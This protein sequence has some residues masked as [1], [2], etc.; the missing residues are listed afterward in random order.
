VCHVN[1]D[2][3]S[4]YRPT[5]LSA[6][7]LPRGCHATLLTQNPPCAALPIT[8]KT[9]LG[10][11]TRLLRYVLLAFGFEDPNGT[12]SLPARY[13][14][15]MHFVVWRGQTLETWPPS[16]DISS[17]TRHP[18]WILQWQISD[19]QAQSPIL[20]SHLT[21]SRTT[22]PEKTTDGPGTKPSNS[23]G[24]PGPAPS[25]LL[26]GDLSPTVSTHLSTRS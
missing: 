12:P 11:L 2:R 22:R 18:S 10:P 9:F 14:Y 25:Y 3:W 17:S 7:L 13:S 16:K 23:E 21:T 1:I 8:Q 20:S 24:W 4:P 15:F 19:P 5:P 6:R 26:D